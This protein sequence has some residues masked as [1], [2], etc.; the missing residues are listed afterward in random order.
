MENL[1][2]FL[3]QKKSKKSKQKITNDSENKKTKIEPYYEGFKGDIIKVQKDKYLFKGKYQTESYD[4]IRVTE[5]PIGMWTSSF[6]EHLESLMEVKDKKGKKKIPIVKNYVDNC[7][8][9]VVDFKIKFHPTKLTDLIS[10]TVNKNVNG[11][12]KALKL[13]TTKKTSNMYLFDEEQKLRKYETIYG[14]IDK[15]YPV[16]IGLYKKRKLNL[17]AEYKKIV[18]LL[19][20][21]A[22]FIQEQCDDEIDLRRKKKPSAKK[23]K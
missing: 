23:K 2:N 9:V 4:M 14:I 1:L 8:D 22:R 21:K 7:T 18:K 12:E 3:N 10:K 15:Y 6:K 19:S 11:L 17:I 13:T 5:L 20:N 16:R